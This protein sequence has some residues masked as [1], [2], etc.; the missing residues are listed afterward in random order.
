MKVA[1]NSNTSMT[2]LLLI[3][4]GKNFICQ[5]IHKVITS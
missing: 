3:Y 5:E 1:V 4:N 2:W